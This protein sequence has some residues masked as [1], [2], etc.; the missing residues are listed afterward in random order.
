MLGPVFTSSS[1]LDITTACLSN[2]CSTYKYVVHTNICLTAYLVRVHKVGA[3]YFNLKLV[4]DMYG[5]KTKYILYAPVQSMGYC[6]HL[7]I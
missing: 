3:I 2:T 6:T 7:F 4:H 5:F 1:S